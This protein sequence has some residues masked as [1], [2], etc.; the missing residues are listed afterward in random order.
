MDWIQSYLNNRQQFVRL[1]DSCSKCLDLQVPQGSV[2]GPTCFILY[3]NYIC[4]ILKLL[5]LVLCADDTNIFCSGDDMVTTEMIKLKT[6]FD[7][8]K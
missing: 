5:K 7:Q 8:N 6:W 1:G 4:Q 3:I 2:L